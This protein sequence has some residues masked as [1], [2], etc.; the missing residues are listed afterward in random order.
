MA[1]NVEQR[2][3]KELAHGS[4]TNSQRTR[5]K[6]SH[7]D[8]TNSSMIQYLQQDKQFQSI[9]HNVNNTTLQ[10]QLEDTIFNQSYSGNTT[11]S[12]ASRYKVAN[13]SNYSKRKQQVTSIN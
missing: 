7:R 4:V 1:K 12:V 10:Q 9:T 5:Q 8:T 2:S 3:G 11:S 13:S 6:S